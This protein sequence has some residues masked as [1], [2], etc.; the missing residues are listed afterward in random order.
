MLFKSMSTTQKPFQS[1]LKFNKT[2][3]N[4]IFCP[5]SI[6][7]SW[8]WY[9]SARCWYYCTYFDFWNKKQ[10]LS[11]PAFMFYLG[12]TIAY[13]EVFPVQGSFGKFVTIMGLKTLDLLLFSVWLLIDASITLRNVRI[14]EDILLDIIAGDRL[15]RQPPVYE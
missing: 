9:F 4:Q 6:L 13:L 15:M 7:I 14:N 5:N 8:A 3:L 10:N 2:L 12:C 1:N 11:M